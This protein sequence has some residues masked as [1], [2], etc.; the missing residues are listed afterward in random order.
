MNQDFKILV[1]RRDRLGDVLMTLPCLIYLR[2]VFPAAEIDFSCQKELHQLLQEFCLGLHIGLVESCN[3]KYEGT[4]FLNGS[5]LDLWEIFKRRIPKRVGLFLKPASFLFLN[6][7]IRQKRSSNGK[8]E[9]ECNLELAELLAAQLGVNE[10]N[11]S[12]PGILPI[13]TE[14]RTKAIRVLENLGIFEPTEIAIFHPGMRGSSLN[15]SLETYLK[16]MSEFE[17]RGFKIVLS[18]GPEKK[19]LEI[20]RELLKYRPDIP[21]ISGLNLSEL[22][23]VFR[24]AKWVVAPSTGPLHLA[25]WVGI[26]TVGLY[27]PIRSQH[28][29]RWA[30]WGG[31]VPAKILFPKI[32]CPAEKDC[33]GIACQFFN[34]M[35]QAD[36]KQLLLQLESV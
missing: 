23:E 5:G 6:K 33:L 9:A 8:N 3:K 25:H 32:E 4:L 26:S 14:S 20:Q 36:W 17:G 12:V 21:V 29:R 15:V 19:D 31:K 34:C 10:K 2:R 1:V 13:Q 22:A 35:D 24:L 7:G 30:P 16:M 11:F 28:S 27:S 18:T